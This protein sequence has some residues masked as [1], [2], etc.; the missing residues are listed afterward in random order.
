MNGLHGYQCNY[1][2]LMTMTNYSTM[3]SSCIGCCT[4]FMMMSWY[5]L[6]CRRHRRLVR[7]SPYKFISILQNYLR[8]FEKW[9]P[10]PNHSANQNAPNNKNATTFWR[11]RLLTQWKYRISRHNK[12]HMHQKQWGCRISKHKKVTQLMRMQDFQTQQKP[13]V[14]KEAQHNAD[15]AFLFW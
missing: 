1:S 5:N 6:L 7:M 4:H 8:T 15:K 11:R 2:H 10:P 9:R 13:H 12:Y 14:T 3:M